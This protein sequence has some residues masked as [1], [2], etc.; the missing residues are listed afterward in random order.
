MAEKYGVTLLMVKK[1]RFQGWMILVCQFNL[2][3]IIEMKASD[4]VKQATWYSYR[5]Y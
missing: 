4:R 1:A 3:Q 5:F 2:K